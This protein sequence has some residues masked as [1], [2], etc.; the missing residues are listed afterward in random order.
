MMA[1]IHFWCQTM[2]IY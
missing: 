2:Q 1:N